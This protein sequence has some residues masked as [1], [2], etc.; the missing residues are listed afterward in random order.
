MINIEVKGFQSAEDIKFVID[1]FTAIVGRS[2][3]GKSALVRA[4]K[5]ALTNAE[6]VSFVRHGPD[7]ARTLRGAKTCKCFASVHIVTEGFDLLWEKGDAV[8][9]YIFNEALYDHPGKGLPEFL[10]SSGLSPVKVGDD[11]SCIQIS[12]QFYPIFLLNKSG[13]IVAETIS[14]VSKLTRV[15]KATKLVEKD[16]RDIQSTKKVREADVDKLRIR[17][18]AYEGLDAAL[19]R[20]VEVESQFGV[21]E[22]KESRLEAIKGYISKIQTLGLKIR[23]LTSVVSVVVPET[24]TIE[25]LS[26]KVEQLSRFADEYGR[27]SLDVANLEWVEGL[28]VPEA[29]PLSESGV[30]LEQLSRFADE[31]DRRS[32]A[33]ANL[34][35]VDM[36]SV[37]DLGTLSESGVRLEQLSKF[38]E[39]YARRESDVRALAWVEALESKVPDISELEQVSTKFTLI[40]SWI[41]RLRALKSKFDV[42]DR[43]TKAPTPDLD[44]LQGLQGKVHDLSRFITKYQSLQGSIGTLE[45]ELAQVEAEEGTLEGE[46]QVLG[47]CPTCVQPL[48]TGHS[49][50]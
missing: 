32:V 22:A 15:N 37:P 44:T 50:A 9:R 30:R 26:P 43:L 45:G 10:A 36:I 5:C 33:V 24:D 38:S 41:T 31:Y 47:V 27:R 25:Q 48:T 4:L 28:E 20:A 19:Q 39:D 3:I 21:I 8:N 6:G 46:I 42:L 14:D 7:C 29:E 17:L 1:G 34:Q 13:G 12:D 2:N 35:W 18:C 16:R 23:G 11:A 40:D 49:H